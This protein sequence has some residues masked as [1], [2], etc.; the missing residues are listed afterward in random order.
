MAQ[1]VTINGSIYPLVPSVEIPKSGGGKA[2]FMDTSDAT[3]AAGDIRS[4]KSAY[5][6][7]QKVNGTLNL[8]GHL[9]RFKTKWNTYGIGRGFSVRIGFA[10]GTY[11]TISNNDLNDRAFANVTSVQFTEVDNSMWRVQY[12]AENQTMN[13]Y[14]LSTR[15]SLDKDHNNA[16]ARQTIPANNLF[17]L[18][19]LEGFDYTYQDKW[20]INKVTVYTNTKGMIC[21]AWMQSGS[22]TSPHFF[23]AEAIPYGLTETNA[24]WKTPGTIPRY[25]HDSFVEVPEPLIAA[26]GGSSAPSVWTSYFKPASNEYLECDQKPNSTFNVSGH[27]TYTKTISTDTVFEGFIQLGYLVSFDD[28]WNTYG[29]G[30]AFNVT[31]NFADGTTQAFPN[32]DLNGHLFAGVDS[33]TFKELEYESWM[34][35]Y[36]DA[37]GSD[38]F[39]V[40]NLETYTRPINSNTNFETFSK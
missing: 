34:V 13:P 12:Y 17:K 31:I 22:D 8:S 32:N 10:D 2:I 28:D 15:W 36:S 4:G 16:Y 27:A 29:S 11:T 18:P 5:V 24:K 30:R 7:G 26:Y 23:T 35:N 25:R 3:A 40:S 6:N 38:V 20:F 33:V 1:D 21:P 19:A 14:I 37:S 9:V 39:Y